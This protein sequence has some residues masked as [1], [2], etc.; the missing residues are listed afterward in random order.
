M[1]G[2]LKL[3][4]NILVY[5]F[6]A[7]GFVL[8]VGYFAVRFGLT[9][10]PGMVDT[11]QEHFISGAKEDSSLF[12]PNATWNTTDEWKTFE[13]AVTKDQV[14]INS[15]AKKTGVEPRMIVSVLAVEQLRLFFTERPVFKEVFAPLKVLG[16]QS[17]FSWGVM[18]IKPDTAI[19][20][21]NNLKNPSSEY[22]PGKEYEHLLDF[23]TA[24]PDEERYTRMTNY[25]DRTYSYLYGA[26]AIK[27]TETAW[28]K[29]GIDISRSPGVVATLFNI[30]FQS[31]APHKDPQIG[32]AEITIDN[33]PYT[34]GSLAHDIYYGDSLTDI[35]P[36]Q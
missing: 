29:A 33:I 3:I 20:I 17:Q 22:Y 8:V 5:I 34:F 15:V 16:V 12:Y 18:G 23:T 2:K 26:L 25:Q 13:A 35:F 19:A 31:V 7:I 21:E 28:Q 36:R 14:V 9:N 6:A 1:K 32:G 24:N 4:F 10:V 11:Q 30:G 27:E